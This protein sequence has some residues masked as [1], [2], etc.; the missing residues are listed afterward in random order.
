MTIDTRNLES[1]L[2]DFCQLN[3]KRQNKIIADVILEKIKENIDQEFPNCTEAEK[4]NRFI[5]R[6]E[7]AKKIIELIEK[8][9]ESQQSVLLS[10]A[11]EKASERKREKTD[12][13]EMEIKINRLGKIKSK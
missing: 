8:L 13:Y 2:E 11:E 5:Y 3:Q 4:H 6:L 12:E 10:E 7:K 9:P 1:L